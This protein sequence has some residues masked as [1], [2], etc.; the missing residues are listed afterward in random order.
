M[1]PSDHNADNSQSMPASYKP[2]PL[3]FGSPRASPFRRPESPASP[4]PLRNSTIAPQNTFTPTTSP[5][6]IMGSASNLD[7][8]LTPSKSDADNWTPRGLVASITSHRSPERSPTRGSE[9]SPQTGQM[10][11]QSRIHSDTN[12]ISK[13]QPGQVRELREG[14]QILDR[15]SDGQIGRE[16]V[17]DMLTQLGT[18]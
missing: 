5:T 10:L 15:D 13:L 14:F 3:S 2:S 6:K 1:A 16:D 4:S 12:A 11:G 8:S 17:I 9:S 7:D 18:D